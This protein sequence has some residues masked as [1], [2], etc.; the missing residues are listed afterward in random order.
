MKYHLQIP[1]KTFCF[2]EYA[3]LVGGTAMLITTKP[4]FDIEFEATNQ[5]QECP[6]HPQSPAG[7]Y[8]KNNE[9]FYSSW[10]VTFKDNYK[11]RGGFGASTAQFIGLSF[12][13]RQ[14]QAP[15]TTISQSSFFKSIWQDYQDVNRELNPSVPESQLPSGYD[16]WSQLIGS[17]S[18]VKR[19]STD[20]AVQFNYQRM[21]WPFADLDFL[22]VPTGF[23][24]A[25]HEHLGKLK[26]ESLKGLSQLSDKMMV[27]LQAKDPTGFLE[28]LKTWNKRL[29]SLDLVHPNTLEILNSLNKHSEVA[30]AKGC[31]ALGADIVFVAFMRG[32]HARIRLI[33]SEMNFNEAYDRSDLWDQEVRVQL[34]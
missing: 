34:C 19:F 10:N 16:L 28:E 18:T 9:S 20:S 31:G 27:S 6:F 29:Q 5:P 26:T 3:A 21:E 8:Y 2:G 15:E 25:T 11:G 12:F 4:G 30:F 23:K 32:E 22:I 33:L 7:L 1:G 24:V 13:K 14:T 17:V